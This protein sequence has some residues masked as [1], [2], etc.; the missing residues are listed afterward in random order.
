M[1]VK[2]RVGMGATRYRKIS[3]A[4][5]VLCA[6]LFVFL[7]AEPAKVD[8]GSWRT[9]GRSSWYHSQ[10]YQE[11]EGYDYSDKNDKRCGCDNGNENTE[12]HSL[13]DDCDE[14]SI[15]DETEGNDEGSQPG[16]PEDDPEQPIDS[17]LELSVDLQVQVDGGPFVDAED[18]A[19][20]PE[21]VVGDPVIWQ[22]SVGAELAPENEER[23]VKITWDK[24]ENVDVTG[25]EVTAGTFDGTTWTVGIAA[26]PAT[27]TINSVLNGEGLG[28][29]MARITEISCD[30]SG[31][32]DADGFCDFED[33]IV[34]NNTNPAGVVAMASDDESDAG[35]PSG[36]GVLGASTSGRGGA[37]LGSQT[38]GQVLGMNSG[39]ALA[40]TGFNSI[41]ALLVGGLLTLAPAVIRIK[42]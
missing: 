26:M 41:I 14:A 37:V 28:V 31:D 9:H 30:D 18:E 11:S 22:V 39:A 35:G 27:L 24:P 38:G 4:V 2:N 3:L 29:S 25:S 15:P 17:E 21:A 5:I 23:T 13:S 16:E 6:G 34:A 1:N 7:I 33:G 20:S 8:A 12:D 36:L 19:S 32:A 42:R 10:P 40:A